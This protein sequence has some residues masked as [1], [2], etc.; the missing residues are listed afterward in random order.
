MI[1]ARCKEM[2]DQLTHVIKKGRLFKA[3]LAAGED[4]KVSAELQEK[5]NKAYDNYLKNPD[6]QANLQ[7]LE[8][9]EDEAAVI[10]DY[11]TAGGD[12][13]ILKALDYHNDMSEGFNLYD[14]C[15][16]KIG[17]EFC[18]IYMP[19]LYWDRP[20]GKWKFWCRIQWAKVC[21]KDP[22]T[23][24]IMVDKYGDNVKAWPQPG[25][26]AKFVPWANGPTKVIELLM[27][28]GTWQ[29]LRAE[30]LPEQLDDK[31]K[32]VLH[33]WHEAA[34]RVTPEEIQKAIPM[35]HPETYKTEVPGVSRFDVKDWIN[36]GM[37]TLKESGWVALCE[38]IASK[39]VKDLGFIIELCQ[40][41]SSS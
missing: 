37:P 22:A 27:P 5:L 40:K 3:F 29:A 25:C 10:A 18:G 35:V 23:A 24:K 15:T 4:F 31:I 39:N 30:R 2:A 26:G 21:E 32:G 17:D 8:E 6:D 20:D 9:L 11:K 34:G 33:E 12:V 7:R 13:E 14:C 36:K 38:L 41:M 28:D 16:R 1:T 19:S